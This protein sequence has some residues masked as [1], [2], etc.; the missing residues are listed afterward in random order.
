[1]LCSN[2]L[3]QLGD[4]YMFLKKVKRADE[5][6]KH[7]FDPTSQVNATSKYTPNIDAQSVDGSNPE[8]NSVPVIKEEPE[9]LDFI[10][11]MLEDAY[12]EAIEPAIE[13]GINLE[14]VED[15][16]Q[17]RPQKRPAR[18][19]KKPMIVLTE[20]VSNILS[21][22]RRSSVD[23][24]IEEM[25]DELPLEGEPPNKKHKT[26]DN[27]S[28]IVT[29]FVLQPFS[30]FENATNTAGN[31]T[32]GRNREIGGDN[33]DNENNSGTTANQIQTI[34]MAA[35]E[36]D[37]TSKISAEEIDDETNIE[38]PNRIYMCKYC[39]KA[40]STSHHLLMHS[41]KSHI[42]HFCTQSFVKVED[43]HRHSKEAHTS[44]KCSLCEKQFSS[45][46]NLRQHLKRVHRIDLPAFVSLLSVKRKEDTS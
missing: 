21:R 18:A 15:I 1:M 5:Y 31:R 4:S 28:I 25:T 9:E 30:V 44:F 36:V 7:L 11:P 29:K 46:S 3:S 19:P 38:D 16:E 34:D 37:P 33:D 42:C 27:N 24:L 45:N 35:V 17:C 20:N 43:L 32:E 39:P 14:S 10:T 6:I 23:D 22:V 8:E 12:G 26:S 41:R 13:D 2:C 40:F